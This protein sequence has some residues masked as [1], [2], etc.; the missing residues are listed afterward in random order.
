MNYR[1]AFH[2]GNHADVL[3]HAALLLCLQRLTEKP[4][5]LTVL[6]THAGRGLY[7]LDADEARRSPE[8][9]DGVG[10][11]WDWGDAPESLRPL[12]TA[13]RAANP[14]GQLRIY[15]GSPMVSAAALRPQDRLILCELHPQEVAALRAAAP[16]WAATHQRDGFGAF[17]ALLPPAG[18]RGLTLL[19]PPYER[20]D[21]ARR[22]V[23]GLSEGLRR[24]RQGV[25]LWWRPLKDRRLID[26][27]DAELTGAAPL[28]ALRLDLRVRPDGEGGLAASS[29]LVINPPYGLEA[30]L[31]ELGPA[32]AARLAQG[33]G[34][35]FTLKRL[36][37]L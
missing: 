28:K 13:L 2:A 14:D 5:A 35:E 4:A 19:D 10:R 12:Q 31:G 18:G 23:A 8:W 15:P 11:I 29:L 16:S 30:A 34:A 3:K 26:A 33:P 32:L 17:A 9:R 24:F 21:E 37:Q 22:C 7:P 36:G 27:A 6:D 1:H 20:P 25:F